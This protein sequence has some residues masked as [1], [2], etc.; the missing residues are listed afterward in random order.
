[1]DFSTK[2]DA[3]IKTTKEQLKALEREQALAIKAQ[4]E[5]LRNQGW[6]LVHIEEYRAYGDYIPGVHVWF[7]PSVE[8]PAIMV[9]EGRQWGEFDPEEAGLSE[10]QYIW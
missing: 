4:E 6:T 1:M 7:H 10:D 3:Q 8:N 9:E 5:Q 2:F